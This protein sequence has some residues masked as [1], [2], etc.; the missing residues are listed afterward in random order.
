MGM[1]SKTERKKFTYSEGLKKICRFVLAILDKSDIYKTS[2]SQREV[3]VI[4]PS[5]LPEN[6]TEKLQEAQL[7]KDLGVP[8]EQVLR[9]LGYEK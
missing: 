4:F 6:M 5:P 7:K 1:L 9:E 3:D 2:E 8:A